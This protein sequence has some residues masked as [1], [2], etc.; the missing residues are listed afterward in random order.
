M[1]D[2]N[3]ILKSILFNNY[4]KGINP[5]VKKLNN[6]HPLI[7][8]KDQND[9]QLNLMKRLYT[10]NTNNN[11]LDQFEGIVGLFF[12]FLD[13]IFCIKSSEKYI[14]TMFNSQTL[15][16]FRA[17]T[18]PLKISVLCMMTFS[19]F[20]I[21]SIINNFNLISPDSSYSSII[22]I[23]YLSFSR[24]PDNITVIYVYSLIIY[25]ILQFCYVLFLLIVKFLS[26]SESNFIENNYPLAKI[27]FT[28][29]TLRINSEDEKNFFHSY[30]IQQILNL[31]DQL[32]E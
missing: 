11:F 8:N 29:P 9:T 26:D 13:L 4:D 24:N 25:I 23:G 12:D 20:N 21:I 15:Q 28:S 22:S 3:K 30:F 19:T 6:Y 10:N 7:M 27:F 5:K 31:T 18:H 16:A 14:I 1:C 32:S 2:E 17:I